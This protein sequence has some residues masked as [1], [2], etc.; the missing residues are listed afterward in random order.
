M[1]CLMPH[2]GGQA[3]F[4]SPFLTGLSAKLGPESKPPGDCAQ[5]P[6]VGEH[7][8]SPGPQCPSLSPGLLTKLQ[9]ARS[10]N[11]GLCP[12]SAFVP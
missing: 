10:P 8:G 9:K 5:V 4:N 12:L 1:G 11:S 2:P 7:R 6:A 3:P